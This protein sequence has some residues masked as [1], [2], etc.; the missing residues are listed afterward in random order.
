MVFSYFRF[1]VVKVE[2]FSDKTLVYFLIHIS[3]AHSVDHELQ[4]TIDVCEG[5]L[6]LRFLGEKAESINLCFPS[7]L[8]PLYINFL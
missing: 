1:K 6:N 2:F 7:A 4:T 5:L 8:S 3:P